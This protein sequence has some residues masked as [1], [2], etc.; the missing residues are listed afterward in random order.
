MRR[1]L[2]ATRQLLPS[3]RSILAYWLISVSF[4]AAAA[5][6]LQETGTDAA[7]LW[8]L[9]LDGFGG[10]PQETLRNAYLEM[11]YHAW[12]FVTLPFV[13]FVGMQP[14]ARS[15][16]RDFAQFLRFSR[17]SRLFIELCRIVALMLVVAIV[18]LPFAAAVVCG[19]W[20]PG[21]DWH[22]GLKGLVA[23][24]GTTLFITGFIYLL[25]FLTTPAEITAA[26]ALVTPFLIS[27]VSTY[28]E[29]VNASANLQRMLPP[30]LPYFNDATHSSVAWAL[31][32]P[33]IRAGAIF[34][35]GVIFL[36]LLAATRTTWLHA[37]GYI[38]RVE[39]TN[40]L[41]DQLS[42]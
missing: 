38:R 39:E 10:T 12:T 8:G 20:H 31:I 26:L 14:L 42:K 17:S 18:S 36:R 25:A 29:K 22:G 16:R 32:H 23:C 41:I 37:D 13:C 24:C 6:G 34:V 28:L 5:M 27:G 9:R 2:S 19:T 30:G 15:L 35:L 4:I 3:T 21:L 40:T 7:A 33:N 11:M 1:L